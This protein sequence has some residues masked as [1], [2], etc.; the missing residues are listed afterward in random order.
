MI[1]FPSIEQY[2]NIIREVKTHHDFQGKDEADAPIYRNTQP[3]PVVTFKGTVK[4]H[5]TNA[6]IV[7]YKDG[8]I[9]YQSRERVLDLRADNAGFMMAMSGKNLDFLFK[10]I[11]FNEHI[12]IFGEWCGQGV[13]HGVAISNVPKMFVIFA[14][15]IDGQWIDF[16][17][18]D[19]D[20]QIYNI[21]QFPI[22]SV[23]VD[24]NQPEAIQ[25]QFFDLTMAVEECCPVGK[26]FG[27]EG[28]GEGI[29]WVGEHNG[30][31]YRFKTKGDKHSSSKVKTIASVD[32]DQLNSLNEF[33]DYA[34]TESRLQQGITKLE[35]ANLLVNQQSTGEYLR[36]VVGDVFKEE[37]DT[38]VQNQLDAKKLG[39]ALSNKA[40]QWYFA[41]MKG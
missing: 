3:Y 34:L 5:G 28:V 10:D 36:W 2:R 20:Q 6:G 35:E 25:N 15:N 33:V 27:F 19:N 12:A 8:H 7:K 24:F 17:R 32:V 16:D 38:I 29:V 26:H 1:K 21:N 18:S 41:N 11:K 37:N 4:L 13:Q 40:R 9:E 30:N 31:N 39:S 23:D 22:W 14:C